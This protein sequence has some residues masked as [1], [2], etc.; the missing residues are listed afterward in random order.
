MNARRHRAAK[1]RLTMSKKP[2]RRSVARRCSA[3]PPRVNKFDAARDFADGYKF[4]VCR[5]DDPPR[6]DSDL[7]NA[8]YEYGETV[9][10]SYYVAMN[11][12]L[13]SRGIETIGTVKACS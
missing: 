12:E 8:G 4:A 6:W 3:S 11:A 1:E 10:E 13:A 2:D 9:K 5:G 7:F